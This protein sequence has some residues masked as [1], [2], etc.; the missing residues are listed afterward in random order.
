MMSVHGTPELALPQGFA[1]AV[2]GIAERMGLPPRAAALLR[3]VAF[4]LSLA[5]LEG[6][7]CIDLFELV[8]TGNALEIPALRQ[9]LLATGL[10]AHPA[11][12]LTAPFV[13]DDGDRLQL[14][15]RFDEERRL[16]RALRVRTV[17]APLADADAIRT[18]IHT[19]ALSGNDGPDVDRQHVAVALGIRNRLTI[20]SGGPGTGKTTTAVT[21]LAALLSGTPTLRIALAAP[22]GKAAQRME[23]A[24]RTAGA[25][26]PT[27]LAG[28]LPEHATTIH[29]LLG[30]SSDGTSHRHHAGNPLPADVVIIDEA[31]MLDLTLATRLIEAV[32]LEARL[33]LIGDKDQLP[34]VEAGAIFRD[35]S[36]R[37]CFSVA[38]LDEIRQA[39]DV[40]PAAL[41]AFT[42]T[43][44]QDVPCA[45]MDEDA[46]DWDDDEPP[47]AAPSPLADCVIWLTR[48]R[49]FASG[50]AIDRLAVAVKERRGDDVVE[51]L[52]AGS[53]P[54][55]HL[56]DDGASQP[57]AATLAAV[58]AGYDDYLDLLIQP[59]AE[60]EAILAAFD[61]HRILCAVRESGRGVE[62]M[63]DAVLRILRR[64]VPDDSSEQIP[65]WRHGLPVLITRNDRHTGLANGDVGIILRRGDRLLAHFPGGPG[66]LRT[67][68][69]QRLP[70]HE[71]AFATTVHKSQGS[72]HRSIALV[73]PEHH[74]PVAS[75][76]LL[77]TAITRARES[78]LILG[79][80]ETLRTAVESSHIQKTGLA[81]KMRQTEG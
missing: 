60:P 16:A 62:V 9:A 54:S 21:L 81:A 59:D 5:D 22:T 17:A 3:R 30:A 41:S 48:A 23:E 12:T 1:R 66:I 52:M 35:I 26:I 74:Q 7:T 38:C 10:V 19:A 6:H 72:E 20:I 64:R 69:P 55:I 18:M 11:S 79:T 25:R 80:P 13:L 46:E 61:R 2:Q 65:P 75:R 31:S 15:R 33:V 40:S 39:L 37:E 76:E 71:P 28:L 27:H 42:E 34:P 70:A 51:M 47:D 67:I 57:D 29:R 8:D 53:D 50:G 14:A 58:V 56:I 45:P 32:P 4:R 24:V 44:L 49:R 43:L 77:Y 73:L 36:G 78:V 63:N 68:A